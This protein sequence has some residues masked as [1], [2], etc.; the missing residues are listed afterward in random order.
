MEER[1]SRRQEKAKASTSAPVSTG[2]EQIQTL[3]CTGAFG[4]ALIHCSCSGC[5]VV[6]L[7]LARTNPQIRSV[8]PRRG[9]RNIAWDE[10]QWKQIRELVEE[11]I[12]RRNASTQEEEEE[13]S[14]SESDE[15]AQPEPAPVLVTIEEMTPCP[16]QAV[17]LTNV[18]YS[19]RGITGERSRDGRSSFDD[20]YKKSNPTDIIE[21]ITSVAIDPNKI[22]EE[23]MTS[24]FDCHLPSHGG[25]DEEYARREGE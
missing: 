15:D 8:M 1:P 17:R 11:E 14:S 13:S 24:A 19:V 16:A 2:E 3:Q 7:L 12:L 6:K 25:V 23:M 18:F 10:E 21:D 20:K 4:A 5:M 9:T 22:L